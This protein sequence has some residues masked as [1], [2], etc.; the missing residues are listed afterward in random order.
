[1]NESKDYARTQCNN[2]NMFTLI[3]IDPHTTVN[4]IVSKVRGHVN[5]P[6]FV[7]SLYIFDPTTKFSIISE[8]EEDFSVF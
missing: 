2:M 6:Y 1:M 5:H 8:V 4:M 3:A 7:R